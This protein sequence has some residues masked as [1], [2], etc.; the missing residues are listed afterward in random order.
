VSP[1]TS[2]ARRLARGLR[3]RGRLLAHHGDRVRCPV[4][5]WRFRAFK[6]DHGRPNAVCWRCGA[7]ARHRALWLFLESRPELLAGAGSL[8]HLAPEWGLRRR[9]AARPGL[10]YVTADLDGNG[11]DER[12]D[13]QA[14]A[15]PDGAFDAIVCSHVLEHVPD[16]AA[17]LRE[18]RRV[19]RP[20][21]WA[22][23]MVPLDPTRAATLEDPAIATPAQREAA[24]WQADHLRLYGLD[25]ADRLRA[26]G[27]EV[28][29]E[30][31]VAALPPAVVA[32]HALHGGD[33]VWLA[34]R[35]AA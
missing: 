18:L 16:D 8:L 28:A 32:R 9:L 11:V 29:R 3:L 14:L 7:H 27:F 15:L 2:G 19:L 12:L 33:D 21:G 26:A 24:Y 23:L 25:F 1:A 31:F 10:R 13:V 20:G 35:P 22:L 17:A 30:R 6:A 34:R 4:C 5:G